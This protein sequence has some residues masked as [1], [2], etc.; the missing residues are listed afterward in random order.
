MAAGEVGWHVPHGDVA[1]AETALRD[2]WARRDRDLTDM[3]RRSAAIVADHYSRDHLIDQFAA[4][5][6]DSVRA[7]A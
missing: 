1:T 3:G 2:A 7:R 4:L 5:L 6:D